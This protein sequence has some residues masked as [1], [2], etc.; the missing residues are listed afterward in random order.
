MW[1]RDS[2]HVSALFVFFN[3][4]RSPDLA[5]QMR[6]LI[7]YSLFS[8]GAGTAVTFQRFLFFQQTAKS[9]SGSADAQAHI[10][11][12]C[13]HVA[14]GQLSSFSA[15]FSINSEVQIRLRGCAGSYGY[16]LLS[17]GI[18]CSFAALIVLLVCVTV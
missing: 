18:R 6:R 5:A 17:C 10:D 9:R 3:R 15:F 12:R 2:S 4:Q 11:I 16:S 13:S 7:G 8:C 1:R 14:Q